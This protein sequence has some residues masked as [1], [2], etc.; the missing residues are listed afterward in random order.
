MND[1]RDIFLVW[2]DT[3]LLL[4]C[5]FVAMSMLLV[6]LVNP[7]KPK[8]QNDVTPAGNMIVHIRWGDG[9][10]VD[11]DLWVRAPG[12][13]AVGYSNKQGRYFNLLRD[14]LGDSN[15]LGGLREEFAFSNGVPPGEYCSTV[16]LYR[17]GSPEL[18]PVKVSYDI[19]IRGDATTWD[20]TKGSI[21]LTH[22]AEE[23]TL[24]CFTLDDRKLLVPGSLNNV[25]RHLWHAQ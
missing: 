14:S 1:E 5:S 9:L 7:P 16:G 6:A 22:M 11:V 12:D 10:D 24:A 25:T 21:V 3:A 17:T 20:I 4:L 23:Q 8:A 19:A 15:N 13:V 2:T 18:L